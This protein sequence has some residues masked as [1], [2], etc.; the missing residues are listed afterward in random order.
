MTQVFKFVF[1]NTFIIRGLSF[2][3]A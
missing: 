1:V 2:S 3:L